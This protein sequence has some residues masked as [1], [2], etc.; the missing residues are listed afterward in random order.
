MTHQTSDVIDTCRLLFVSGGDKLEYYRKLKTLVPKEKWKSFLDA[1]MEETHFSEYFSFGANDEAE[2]YV[3][4]RDN[5]RLF[6]L[7]SSTK[8]HQLEA[9]MKYSYYL[10]TLIRSN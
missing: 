9:L 5:E 6:K 4:E 8:Y 1:M 3:N 10:K 7:L 2:I